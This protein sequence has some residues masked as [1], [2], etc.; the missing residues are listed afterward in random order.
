[1]FDSGTNEQSVNLVTLIQDA[2]F[3][4][5]NRVNGVYDAVDF[6]EN[7]NGEVTQI[8]GRTLVD[9]HPVN[10]NEFV[11]RSNKPYVIYGYASV[12]ASQTLTVNAGARI[13]FHADSELLYKTAAL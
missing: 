7:E 8:R 6:G 13:H 12:P 4:Y 11:W 3:I 9:N 10:G 2:Y 5:P 1:M